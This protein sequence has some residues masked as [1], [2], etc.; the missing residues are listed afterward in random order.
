MSQNVIVGVAKIVYVNFYK[1]TKV[2]SIVIAGN[3]IMVSYFLSFSHY[4]MGIKIDLKKSIFI[5]YNKVLPI[6]IS[7]A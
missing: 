7:V 3:E 1:Y 6:L 2:E 4:K 5:F